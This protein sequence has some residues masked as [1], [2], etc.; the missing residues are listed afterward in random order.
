MCQL[1]LAG[2]QA[3][4]GRIASAKQYLRQAGQKAEELP[5]FHLGPYHDY[6]TGRVMLAAGALDEAWRAFAAAAGGAKKSAEP[7]LPLRAQLRLALAR[8]RAGRTAQAEKAAAKAK[9]LVGKAPG[10]RFA[11]LL[12]HVNALTAAA[13]GNRGNATR[14]FKKAVDILAA[15]DTLAAARAR[16]DFGE[17]FARAGE[18]VRAQPLLAAAARYFEGVGNK[19]EAGRISALGG[20][21]KTGG[22]RKRNAR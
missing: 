19:K 11:G 5:S 12:A 1:A 10:R 21:R 18:T 15:T 7:Y 3:E 20:K 8:A 4:A 9:G 2:A 6:V 22:G 13:A 16:A 17:Y 14:Q